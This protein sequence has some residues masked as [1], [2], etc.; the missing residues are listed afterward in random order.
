MG[1]KLLLAT[2]TGAWLVG[3]TAAWIWLGV[4]C[5]FTMQAAGWYWGLS[6][7]PLAIIMAIPM[8]VYLETNGPKKTETRLEDIYG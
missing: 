6:W 3:M 7:I 1:R 5:N 8:T 4:A 2:I